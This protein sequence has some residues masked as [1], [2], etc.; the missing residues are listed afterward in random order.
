METQ[1]RKQALNLGL[2]MGLTLILV[3]TI[4]YVVN[5]GWLA[6]FWVGLLNLVLVFSFALF[7]CYAAR[8]IF[9][10]PS[11]KDVFTSYTITVALGLIISTLFTIILFNFIDT[12]AADIIKEKSIEEVQGIMERFNAPQADIDKAVQEAR[13]ADNNFSVG[14]QIQGYFI[15]LAIMLL[16]GLLASLL[17]RKKDPTLA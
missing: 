13:N 4:C 14:S 5:V 9:K 10:F 12:D 11:F 1:A 2:Y 8:K 17:F 6:N 16:I 3:T 15:F 7:S